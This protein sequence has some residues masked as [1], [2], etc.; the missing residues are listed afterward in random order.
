MVD[1]RCIFEPDGKGQ[2]IKRRIVLPHAGQNNAQQ[3]GTLFLG[4]VVFP[5]LIHGD[6]VAR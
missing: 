5:G 2:R 1:A 3:L 4:L 6:G